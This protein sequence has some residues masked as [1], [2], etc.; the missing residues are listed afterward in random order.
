MQADIDRY[1][2]PKH[3][4]SEKD[5]ACPMCR[6]GQVRFE[7]AVNKYEF[8]SCTYCQFVFCPAITP[9]YLAQL[10]HD[11]KDDAPETG[12]ANIS[13]LYRALDMFEPGRSLRIL[14]FGTGQSTLPDLLRQQGHRAIAVDMVLPIHHHP[15]RLTGNLLELKLAPEQ[16]DIV[17]SFQVF[18]HLPNP[19]PILDE[20]LRLTRP[21]GLVLIHTD[22][23]TPERDQGFTHWWY[24]LP[25][26]HCSFYRHR[27]FEVYLK[28]TPHQLI[29]RDSKCVIIQK[30]Q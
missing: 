9:E 22:M 4:G 19:K 23:E 27:T 24:V 29:W 3:S 5:I 6:K 25:P 8:L 13:F 16:F 28:D 14:D 18:E 2:L 15:D 12:W 7:G 1:N 11:P 17:F 20:L 10:Y 21:K 26:E 30:H